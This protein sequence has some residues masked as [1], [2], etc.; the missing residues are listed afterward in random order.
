MDQIRPL[1]TRHH[2]Q[3][4]VWYEGGDEDRMVQWLGNDVGYE[5]QTSGDIG[6]RMAYALRRSAADGFDAVVLVGADIPGLTT[7][8]LVDAYGRLRAEKMVFGPAEDGG[9]YLIGLQ[10]KYL[11]RIDPAIFTDIPWSSTA[12]LTKTIERVEKSGLT[13]ALLPRLGDVDH[14]EDMVRWEAV[15]AKKSGH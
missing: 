9:Y 1:V 15:M 8:I 14:P 3:V 5:P 7:A 4:T 11:D 6:L 10:T 12:V 13:Y 2:I